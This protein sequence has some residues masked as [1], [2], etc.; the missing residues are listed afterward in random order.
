[1]V[2]T[3]DKSTFISIAHLKTA[4]VLRYLFRHNSI[5]HHR[6]KNTHYANRLKSDCNSEKR[7]VLLFCYKSCKQV[8]KYITVPLC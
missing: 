2:Q 1:M 7:L 4:Q 5:K 8:K 3:T 6:V